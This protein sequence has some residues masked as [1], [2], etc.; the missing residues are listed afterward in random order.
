MTFEELVKLLK[1]KEHSSEQKNKNKQRT[2]FRK[3]ITHG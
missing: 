1:Q 3:R 2:K